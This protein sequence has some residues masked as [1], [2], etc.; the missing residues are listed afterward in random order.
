[1]H[2][3][4]LSLSLSLFLETQFSLISILGKKK[5]EE[6]KKTSLM[7]IRLI[8]RDDLVERK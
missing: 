4:F 2:T 8:R 3:L 7:G 1:M 6:E 5:K